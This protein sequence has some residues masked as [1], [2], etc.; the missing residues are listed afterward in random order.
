[1]AFADLRQR[2]DMLLE[3]AQVVLGLAAQADHR[4]DGDGIAERLGFEIG[5]V[6]ADHAGLLERADP[7]QA[8][9]GGQP[10]ALGEIDVGDPPLGLEMCQDDPVDRIER[11]AGAM[12]GAINATRDVRLLSEYF[13]DRQLVA[14]GPGRAK[15]HR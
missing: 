1:M 8:R 7:A 6:A 2:R 12:H 5:V 3:R 13:I 15:Y 14:L 4:E 10:G 9:R 11:E